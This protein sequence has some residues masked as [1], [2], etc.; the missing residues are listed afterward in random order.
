MIIDC[1]IHLNQY[2]LM[3]NVPS[4]EER[5]R[6]LQIEMASNNVDY[7]LDLLDNLAIF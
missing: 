6:F 4:L 7:A 1:H 2:E 3:E 5:L